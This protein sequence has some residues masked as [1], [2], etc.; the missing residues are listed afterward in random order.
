MVHAADA[1]KSVQH[2]LLSHLGWPALGRDGGGDQ[3]EQ[4]AGDLPVAG[5]QVP[6]L[7]W[8]ARRTLRL[9]ARQLWGEGN[10]WYITWES[11]TL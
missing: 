11:R 8:S 9:G 7:H 3:V 5:G 10:V 4:D 6:A 1:L 2:A